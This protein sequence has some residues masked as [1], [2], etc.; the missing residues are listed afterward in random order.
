VFKRFIICIFVLSYLIAVIVYVYL[1]RKNLFYMVLF[2]FTLLV[3]ISA[4]SKNRM[5]FKPNTPNTNFIFVAGRFLER[6]AI[7][8][9]AYWKSFMI[10]SL[11]RRYNM[12]S[13]SRESC[14]D[15]A[16]Q[17]LPQRREFICLSDQL[18]RGENKSAKSK[19]SVQTYDDYAHDSYRSS[20]LDSN[21]ISQL[22]AVPR[23]EKPSFLSGSSSLDSEDP[24]R[25]LQLNVLADGLSGLSPDMGLFSRV[26]PDDLQWTNRKYKLLHE[27]TQYDPDVIMLQ[28]VDHCK[29]FMNKSS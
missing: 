29:S 27:I 20:T 10:D 18:S 1:I 3:A 19:S 15:D 25:V 24:I 21:H 2:C 26:S 7:T 11:E 17:L 5:Q 14:L 22:S 28:E 6:N 13:M 16:I 4:L 8:V 12:S 23:Q 9:S